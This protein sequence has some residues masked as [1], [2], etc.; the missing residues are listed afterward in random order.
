MNTKLERN[1]TK[2]A[3]MLKELENTKMY[4]TKANKHAISGPQNQ[5]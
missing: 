4:A 2:K 1:K 3:E 5:C